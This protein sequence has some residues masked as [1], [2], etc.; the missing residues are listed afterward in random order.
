[1]YLE[2]KKKTKK[3]CN[4]SSKFFSLNSSTINPEKIVGKAENAGNHNFLLF[5]Q[6]FLTVL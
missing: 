5:Q 3:L 1:M 6:C 4:S 2:G